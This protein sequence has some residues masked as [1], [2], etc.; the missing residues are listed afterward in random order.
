MPSFKTEPRVLKL[1]TQQT[2]CSAYIVDAFPYRVS[3]VGAIIN[4]WR[5]I[6]GM[7]CLFWPE[8]LAQVHRLMLRI[9]FCE[10]FFTVP[11]IS[12]DGAGNAF[13]YMA[14]LF[15]VAFITGVCVTQYFDNVGGTGIHH[16]RRNI[17]GLLLSNVLG[18]FHLM[19]GIPSNERYMIA[20]ANKR[21]LTAD[22]QH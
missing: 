2:V 9:G 5:L 15:G 22:D 16:R 19:L 1:K 11:G 12:T 17:R 3:M 18:G 13:G 14:A 7:F 4:F 10:P 20:R 8:N 6:G 21:P